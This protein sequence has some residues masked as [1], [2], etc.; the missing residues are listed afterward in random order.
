MRATFQSFATFLLLTLVL[1]GCG[2]RTQVAQDTTADSLLSANPTEV[3]SGDIT[4]STSYQ[5]PAPEAPVSV[6]PS[7]TPSRPKPKPK[8]A[9]RPETRPETPPEPLGTLVPAGTPIKIT[10]DQKVSS[11]TAVAG[12]T[13]SGTVKDA[14]VIGSEA[15]IPA[16]ARV[17]GVVTGAAPAQKGSRAFLVLA[18][19]S[20]DVNGASYP[21]NATTDS[22]IAGSTRARNLGA[23]AGSAAAGALIGKAIGGSNKGALIGGLIGGAAATGAVSASKGYQVEMKEGAELAFT[24]RQQVAIR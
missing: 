24:T 18:I 16:G 6:T 20:I 17:T 1:G 19:K 13:W 14:V 3:T 23:I 9:P 15:P 4:P 8:P 5:E 2:Q 21:M 22:I 12:D 11:E 10:F 7:T